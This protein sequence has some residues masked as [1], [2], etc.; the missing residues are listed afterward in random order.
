MSRTMTTRRPTAAELRQ[1]RQLLHTA[2]DCRQLRHAE[3][4]VLFAEGWD[5]AAITP[6]L[7]LH[8]HTAHAYL[9]AFD[10]Q[11]LDWLRHD[12]HGGVPPRITAQQKAV[13]GQLADQ[14]PAVVGLLYGRWS[15]AKLRTY[16][17]KQRLV[18]AISREH[19]RRVLEKGGSPCGASSVSSSAPTRNGW[20]S[21]GESGRL[22][23]TFPALASCCSSTSRSSLSV[24]RADDAIAV[25]VD[26]SYPA[27]RRRGASSTCSCSPRPTGAAA[28]EPSSPARGRSTSAASSA[29]CDAGIVVGRSGWCST[30]TDPT[31][32]SAGRRGGGCGNLS[33]VGSPWPRGVPTITRW[34]R[35]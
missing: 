32:A 5:A 2:T 15:L 25:P 18:K 11:G 24:P 34:K 33:S 17:I 28:G 31:R 29:A 8:P 22:G 26:W 19:R 16:A 12:N 3:A 35:S 9:H 27:S 1:L 14:S 30:T 23:G 10:R 13:L 4:V 21:A 6:F 7:A 20:P